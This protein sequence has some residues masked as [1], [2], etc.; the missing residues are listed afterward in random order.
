MR[1]DTTRTMFRREKHYDGVLM[2]Q[3]RVQL[4][5]DF[6]EQQAIT[7]YREETETRDVVG[8][9]GTPLDPPAYTH[10]SGFEI[11]GGTGASA[12]SF[13]IGAGRYYVD[14]VLCENEATTDYLAQAQAPLEYPAAANV[15]TLLGSSTVG[16][17]YLDV[18]HRN[19]TLLEDPS[20][21]ETALGEADTTTRLKT[22]WQVKVMPLDTRLGKR[23][24]ALL[25]A[26]IGQMGAALNQDGAVIDQ[27]V[28][29]AQ[30]QHDLAVSLSSGINVTCGS[31]FPEWD[32]MVNPALG[33]LKADAGLPAPAPAP[34][35][36]PPTAGYRRLENQLYRVEVH[37]GGVLP[38]GNPTFKWSRE[39]GSLV[40][41]ILDFDSSDPTWITVRDLGRDTESLAFAPGDWVEVVNDHSELST[42]GTQLG[43]L[44]T[45]AIVD[46]GQN[47][48]QLS[49]AP[50]SAA[51]ASLQ[52]LTLNPRLR[53]WDQSTLA[54]I[55]ADPGLPA[56]PAVPGVTPDGN[57]IPIGTD[58]IPL[59][60][61]IAVT[62]SN[63]TYRPGDY[64]QIPARTATGDIEWPRLGTTPQPLPP[65]GVKHHYCRLAL[66]ACNSAKDA[67]A[68]ISDCR[69]VFPP[70]TGFESLFYLGGDGQEVLPGHP[71]PVPLPESLQVGVACGK[72]P[73]AG[74]TVRFQVLTGGG[75]VGSG[76]VAL[77][78]GPIEV[79]TGA[80]GVA[81]CS[82]SVT[83][84][85]AGVPTTQQV[86]ATLLDG[87]GG[88]PV[89]LPVTFSAELNLSEDVAYD[90]T[91]TD[92]QA[93]E[94][95]TVKGALDGLCSLL[96]PP[97]ILVNAVYRGNPAQKI[98]LYNDDDVAVR[99]LFAPVSAT[100]LATVVTPANGAAAPSVFP[101]ISVLLDRPIDLTC[102][103][104]KSTT[105]LGNKTTNSHPTCYV[106][107][108][109]PWS[110][111]G[112]DQAARGGQNPIGYQAVVLA[113]DVHVVDGKL[114]VWSPLPEARA[115]L[116]TYLAE[117][118]KLGT[119]RFLARFTLKGS[120]IHTPRGSNPLLF[121]DG[122]PLGPAPFVGLQKPSGDG[123][124][125]GDFE[126][127]FWL[128]QSQT[129][130]AGGGKI[131]TVVDQPVVTQ[132]VV[133][134][135]VVA[136]PAVTQPVT[137]P[138][139][140]PVGPPVIVQPVIDHPVG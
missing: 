17:V 25:D 15:T 87:P 9:C 39:N 13:T 64:W 75:L 116:L 23:Q 14:G 57:G 103:Q 16:L 46:P 140:Q 98:V 129:S 11:L 138:V 58:P 97:A 102:V 65:F 40:T 60:D 128:T 50:P 127:W 67:I 12:G 48:I 112:V 88:S 99:D 135:P 4:D 77:Q 94:V 29:V 122:E 92:L 106:T 24:A 28:N 19:I 109:L 52:D 68:V 26:F 95:T 41:K 84:T 66:V 69:N 34:C 18:W 3:G 86:Q 132:P 120:F 63:G 37:H 45:I 5:A 51:P 82:W 27:P 6:N 104:G 35:L 91:C 61:G 79:V 133:A 30:F 96:H 126:L 121:L 56:T 78:T 125:G 72:A 111:A 73:V 54:P 115:F 10:A 136:Q 44:T 38:G 130:R 105:D 21:H 85:G 62:F 7:R 47:A 59:E 89:H 32:S 49:A 80:N 33:T 42:D 22:S 123:R 83:T 139:V 20:I 110:P 36:P 90:P 134:Q 31:A 100:N 119:Q 74:A 108:F 53:R 1:I 107:I 113:D 137:Q 101:G 55:P 118:S 76:P 71:G 131:V 81:S 93:L 43:F 2:Q 8:R 70:L 114:V 124:P 117:L